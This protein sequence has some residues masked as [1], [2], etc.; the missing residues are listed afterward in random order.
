MEL[1]LELMNCESMEADCLFKSLAKCFNGEEGS[2]EDVNF[3]VCEGLKTFGAGN[4]VCDG[5][6]V[7]MFV[8]R[9]L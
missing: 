3:R 6:S 2:P 7:S 5:R 8:K 4:K 9:E 1:R